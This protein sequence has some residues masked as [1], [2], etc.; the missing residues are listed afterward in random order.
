MGA[1]PEKHKCENFSHKYF[2]FFCQ[3]EGILGVKN[4]LF[5]LK[6]FYLVIRFYFTLSRRL[7]HNY[8]VTFCNVFQLGCGLNGW[9]CCS[10]LV[11]V[12][13]C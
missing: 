13:F 7:G 11:C 6:N 8:L 10:P 12:E 3:W 2:V 4:S 1:L 9:A 5:L